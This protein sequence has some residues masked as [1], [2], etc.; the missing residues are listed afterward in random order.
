VRHFQLELIGADAMRVLTALLGIV[1]AAAFA[2]AQQPNSEWKL[3]PAELAKIE[4]RL[5]AVV[6]EQGW[7]I[8][9]S[10]NE[11]RIRRDRPAAMSLHVPN[12][13]MRA[14]GDTGPDLSRRPAGELRLELVLR[15]A[16]PM[17]SDE[18]ARLAA[19]N[20]ASTQTQDE[21]RK[22]VRVSYKFDEFAPTTP[23]E[24]QRVEDYRTAVARLPRHVLPDFYTPEYSVRYIHRWHSFASPTDASID[25]ECQR[26]EETLTRCFGMYDTLAIEKRTAVGR[27]EPVEER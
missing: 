8:F 2:S 18:Y 10:G 4:S 19:I 3:P 6:S 9:A 27:Y 22:A 11:V 25:E 14:D 17:S 5:R 13:P 20:A 23:E 1:L 15:F 12:A 21:L 24:L 16:P 26:I 7:T